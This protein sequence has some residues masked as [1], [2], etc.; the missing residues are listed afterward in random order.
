MT[1]AGKTHTLFKRE[2][3]KYAPWYVRMQRRGKDI[4][5]SLG[6]ADAELAQNRAETKIEAVLTDDQDTLRRTRL[7][8]P[9][10][11]RQS[12]TKPR[13]RTVTFSITCS[14]AESL[15]IDERAAS[16]GLDRSTYLMVLANNDLAEPGKFAIIPRTPRAH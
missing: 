6:T 16:L 8:D 15:A 1:Y 13:V 11:S 12:H 2:Q 7:R 3:S 9:A 4:W 14:L 10:K 5:A